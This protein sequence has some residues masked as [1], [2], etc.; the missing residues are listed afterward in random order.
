[1]RTRLRYV[2]C[3][4]ELGFH[5]RGSSYCNVFRTDHDDRVCHRRIERQEMELQVRNHDPMNEAFVVHFS[6]LPNGH[7]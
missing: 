1:M 4:R 6:S 7:R 3:G 5:R 2:F